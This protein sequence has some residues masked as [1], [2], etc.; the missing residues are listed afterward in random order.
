[1]LDLCLS[2]FV[3][4]LSYLISKLFSK[5]FRKH[6]I[7]APFIFKIKVWLVLRTSFGVLFAFCFVLLT[8]FQNLLFE[9]GFCDATMIGS[10]I[11]QFSQA[12]VNVFLL[13]AFAY[14][15]LAHFAITSQVVFA[16]LSICYEAFVL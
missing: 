10:G 9:L 12:Q 1:M 8:E 6:I 11:F 5:L 15:I 7:L 13:K 14:S 3:C 2:C 16:E 4:E